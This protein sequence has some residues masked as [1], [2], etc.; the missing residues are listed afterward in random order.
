MDE[1]TAILIVLYPCLI[2]GLA[3]LMMV[4]R[5]RF[6]RLLRMKYQ[7]QAEQ[8]QRFTWAELCKP[9]KY[10]LQKSKFEWSL[11]VGMPHYIKDAAIKRAL[12]RW[13]TIYWLSWTVLILTAI[14]YFST[15]PQM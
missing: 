7:K 13:Q 4:E 1:I 2:I 5:L 11:L 6:N 14:V 8:L 15:I 12:R 3:G 9:M 10:Q